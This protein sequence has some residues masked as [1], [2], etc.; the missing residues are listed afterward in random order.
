MASGN[1]PAVAKDAKD[2][3]DGG[4]SPT[5]L[6]TLGQIASLAC[7]LEVVAAKPGNVYRGADFNDLHLA[8][9]LVSGHAVAATVDSHLHRPPGELFRQLVIATRANVGTNTNL[10]IL[11][12]FVPVL[13]VADRHGMPGN[14][15]NFKFVPAMLRS[16]IESWDAKDARDIYEGIQLAQAGSLG[17]VDDHD[18]SQQAPSHILIGMAAASDRDWIARQ[19]SQG[20]SD[21]LEV[22]VPELKQNYLLGNGLMDCVVHA[23]VS[24]LARMGDSL[25]A[26]KCG[27]PTALEAQ[28]RACAVVA[29]HAVSQGQQGQQGRLNLESVTAELA[30]FDFWLRSDGNR[31]N[32]GTTADLIAAALLIGL[33]EGWL[34]LPLSW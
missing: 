25:I 11:L 28:R 21:I 15:T 26:R 9:F 14:P 24:S 29:A 31:R 22:I 20:Y 13:R 30:D 3:I 12:L 19:Y 34:A 1:K 6:K 2:C 8:D 7:C 23:H 27:A 4:E 16:E 18:L 33:L 32:P 17:T 10:G 5:G